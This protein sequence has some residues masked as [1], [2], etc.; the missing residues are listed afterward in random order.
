MT[1]RRRTQIPRIGKASIRTYHLDSKTET[2]LFGPPNNS[3]QE[4]PLKQVL[5]KP[6]HSRRLQKWAV[7]LTQFDLTYAPRTAIKGQV[8]ADFVAEFTFPIDEEAQQA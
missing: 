2:L 3:T 7:E 1:P 4:L 8:L 5:C 6:E